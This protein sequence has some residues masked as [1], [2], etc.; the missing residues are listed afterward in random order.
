MKRKNLYKMFLGEDELG[1]VVVTKEFLVIHETECY[2]FYIPSFYEY[3]LSPGRRND[4]ESEIQYARRHKIVKKVQKGSFRSVFETK[5]KALRHLKLMKTRQLRHMERQRLFIRSFLS[6]ENL[7]SVGDML[8]VPN[9]R[10]LVLEYIS[11]D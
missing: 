11:F 5:D 2:F 9:S 3:M 8:L 10:D 7:E 6:C 1:L 4:G